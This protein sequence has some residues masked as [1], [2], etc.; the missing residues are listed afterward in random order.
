MELNNGEL[1]AVTE[2]GLA[3]WPKQDVV[4][5]LHAHRVV[6]DMKEL[7]GALL[8]EDATNE[9]T[10]AWVGTPAGGWCGGGRLCR[11]VAVLWKL[12]AGPGG[13]GGEGGRG[14][15]AAAACVEGLVSGGGARL[16]GRRRAE[17]RR[18]G[19]G[20]RAAVRERSER[21]GRV[22]RIVQSDVYCN[23]ARTGVA[24]LPIVIATG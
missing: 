12:A 21:T 4:K 13:G 2:G 23:L 22:M 5:A 11:R 1:V 9:D 3:N 8:Q 18:T 15:A 10:C 20:A 24:K 14:A 19:R 6:Q 7:L 16:S 17:S